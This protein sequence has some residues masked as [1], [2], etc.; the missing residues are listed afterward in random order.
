[1]PEVFPSN[2]DLPEEH[3]REEQH[4]KHHPWVNRF[5]SA[6][7]ALFLAIILFLAS[8]ALILWNEK[9]AVEESW[10]LNEGGRL[11]LPLQADQPDAENNGQLIHMSGA[12]TTNDVVSDEI[13]YISVNA[14]KMQRVVEMYQWN[15]EEST[16][17]GDKAAVSPDGSSRKYL[18][19]RVWSARPISSAKFAVIQGHANQPMSLKGNEYVASTVKVGG[20]TLTTPFI[21]Q[22][23]N[24]QDYPMTPETFA[25]INPELDEYKLNGSEFYLGA[26]PAAP[27]IGDIRV[28]Y[29]VVLPGNVIS[30]IGK[31][32]D[33]KIETYHTDYSA[34]KIVADGKV[35]A[36]TMFRKEVNA[37]DASL[38]WQLRVFSWLLMYT[39]IVLALYP[40]RILSMVL[41]FIG[42]LVGFNPWVLALFVSLAFALMTVAMG[43]LNYRP[44]L[45]LGLLVM[46]CA[47]MIMTC[48]LQKKQPKAIPGKVK[49]FKVPPK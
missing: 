34:I 41:P 3:K 19:T 31:Q 5:G 46:G 21:D 10:R 1:M 26:N 20:F 28:R 45:A 27:E 23:N 38:T 32:N 33:D 16:D 35:D 4:P 47:V 30:V 40:A 49:Y 22:L 6:F 8:F 43:W 48:F 39:S 13:F 12:V 42:V 14:V 25:R 24:Y 9:Q 44:A 11:I 36:D 17:P 37:R 15:E 29:R 7:G 2:N 18:Y